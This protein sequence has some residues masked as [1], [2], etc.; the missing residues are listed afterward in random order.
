L[1]CLQEDGEDISSKKTDFSHKNV[2]IMINIH[3]VYIKE[4]IK[5]LPELESPKKV[6]SALTVSHCILSCIRFLQV[7]SKIVG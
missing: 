7:V 3:F 4:L 5:M 1:K 2:I 6:I